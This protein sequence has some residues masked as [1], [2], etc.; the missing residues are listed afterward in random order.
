MMNEKLKVL[1]TKLGETINSTLSDSEQ[2]AD[3]V[4]E[5]KDAG[6][7]IFVILEA[8]I[9]CHPSG[10]AEHRTAEPP[11]QAARN[12]NAAYTTADRKFLHTLRIDPN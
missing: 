9:G 11:A 1:M 2:I 10:S 3:V 4:E 12:N 5:I 7:D 8:T 6:F